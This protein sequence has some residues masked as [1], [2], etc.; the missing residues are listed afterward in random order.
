MLGPTGTGALWM[1]EMHL[2]P[3][4]LGGGAIETVSREGYTLV[5]GYERYEAGTPN[6]A[7]GIGLSAAVDYL[8]K[9][10]MD[11]V[12][13]HEERLTARM[14]RGLDRLSGVTVYGARSPLPHIGV[15]SF[16]V[17]G[18]EPHEVAHFLGEQAE[19]MVRSGH[20]CCMPLMQQ[21]GLEK[22]T[23]RAS[24]HLYNTERDVD[25]LLATLVDLT[26]GTV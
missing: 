8:Q 3:L 10:G 23:V 18:Y 19:I 21:M 6:I 2:D 26:K 12:R 9:I 11:R 20:H 24:L 25:T 16:T 14:I 22:G 17:E 7:G 15:I 13:D 4:L 1:K 5:S